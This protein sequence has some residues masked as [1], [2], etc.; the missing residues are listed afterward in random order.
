MHKPLSVSSVNVKM[1]MSSSP[2]GKQSEY[3]IF[4]AH[5]ALSVEKILNEHLKQPGIMVFFDVDDTLIRPAATLFSSPKGSD[6]I[7]HLKS[8]RHLHPQLNQRLSQWRVTRKIMLTDKEWPRVFKNL[9]DKNS[10]F[11]GL[12]QMETGPMG[13]ISRIEEWRHHELADQNLVFTSQYKDKKDVCLIPWDKSA[14]RNY[15]AASYFYQGIFF[16]G[17]SSKGAVV[18]KILQDN[19]WIRHIIFIDDR[20]HHLE[21]VQAVCQNH[22]LLFTGIQFR[23]PSSSSIPIE[24]RDAVMEAQKKAFLCGQWLEDQEALAI[25]GRDIF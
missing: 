6:F 13:A 24:Y 23:A 8:H 22:H 15:N 17:S 4:P 19:A 18:H 16:T 5:D 21:D 1:S 12:T 3:N 11:Y 10:V 2:T 14:E 9:R 25:L 7:D 20:S